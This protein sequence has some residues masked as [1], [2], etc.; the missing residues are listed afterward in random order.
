VPPETG[1][2]FGPG[3]SAFHQRITSNNSYAHDKQ[4]DNPGQQ[5]EGSTSRL[6]ATL[7]WLKLKGLAGHWLV[8]QPAPVRAKSDGRPRLGGACYKYRTSC[9]LPT[10]PSSIVHVMHILAHTYHF[11]SSPWASA[12]DHYEVSVLRSRVGWT[13]A[14]NNE[15]TTLS[16][17][18]GNYRP[19]RN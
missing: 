18:E 1:S 15:Q 13:S 7:A 8:Q 2:K 14:H 9:L 6:L 16:S 5:K 12:L 10:Y 19:C 17:W 3:A 11:P 4:G